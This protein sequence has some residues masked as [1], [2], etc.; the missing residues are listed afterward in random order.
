MSS[1][2]SVAYDAAAMGIMLAVLEVCKRALDSLPNIEVITLLFILF[3][4]SFGWKTM[5]VSIAFALIECI[6]WG[7]GPWTVTYFYVW[8]LLVLFIM[9]TR[10]Q[11]NDSLWFY[12]ITSGIYGLLFGW[13]CS[14]YTLLIGGFSMQVS[15]WIAGIPYDLVH[16]IGNF[17]IC[18]LLFRPLRKV[19]KLT[20]RKE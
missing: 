6:F 9:L 16:G 11:A 18:L 17:V 1:K 4:L 19:M 12:S 15:W 7:F 8:P 2:R 20:V 13:L 5:A 3:T 10:K 14:F